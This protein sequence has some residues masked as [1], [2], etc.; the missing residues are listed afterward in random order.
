MIVFGDGHHFY[1]STTVTIRMPYGDLGEAA[2][3]TR[4][5]SGLSGISAVFLWWAELARTWS[6]VV[7]QA[8]PLGPAEEPQHLVR[9]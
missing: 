5:G 6:A 1:K 3:A 9:V 4:Q 7:G 2:V 8:H